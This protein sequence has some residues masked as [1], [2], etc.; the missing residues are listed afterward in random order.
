MEANVQRG[1]GTAAQLGCPAAGKTG[2]TNNFTD[3]WFDGFTTSLNT[4]V[5]VGYP[6]STQSMSAVPGYGPMFGGK[7]PALIWHDFMET[8]MQG[9]KC[10]RRSRS[11][12]S[13]SWPSRSSASTPAPAPP[14]AVTTRSPKDGD[15]ATDTTTDK[16]D[17]TEGQGGQEVPAEPV[18][19][20]AAAG[21]DA[22]RRRATATISSPLRSPRR[23]ASAS[24]ELRPRG[25]PAAT[26]TAGWRR[27]KRSSS[28]ARSSRPCRTRCSACS[29][30]T[31]TTCWATWR[32]RCAATGSGSSRATG[33]AC[34]L[35]PYDL[36]RARIVYRH[37]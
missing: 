22:R 8:A 29:S 18:R 36:D 34:E 27:K 24:A 15:D 33:C 14:A 9:R 28:R 37:R 3:A 4:A 30:T 2:T 7:A 32:A 20:P 19:V 23:A 10:E 16:D 12:R 21:P 35:S 25:A 17:K 13:R 26:V 31:A 1:T 6:G 11:R 5:W